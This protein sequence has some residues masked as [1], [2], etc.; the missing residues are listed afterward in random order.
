MMSS[1]FTLIQ[2][3]SRV[4]YIYNHAYAIL[5]NIPYRSFIYHVMTIP[6]LER[7]HVERLLDGF[8]LLKVSIGGF[9]D[10]I[11]IS[12]EGSD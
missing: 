3:K 2:K 11:G 9:E 7:Y 1:W 5:K 6:Q 12:I 10:R 4:I 8:V